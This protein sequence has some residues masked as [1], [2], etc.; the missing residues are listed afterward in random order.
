[1]DIKCKLVE[2]D[3]SAH[4][5]VVRYYTDFMTEEKLASSFDGKGSVLRRPDGSPVRCRTDVNL[6]LFTTPT[7]EDAIL[8]YVWT[9]CAPNIMWFEL[10]EK[11][12][13]PQVD[14][15]MTQVKSM[16]GKEFIYTLPTNRNNHG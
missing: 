2:C 5:V 6:N 4:S 12:A 3:D 1:M 9:H 13:D 10:Q 16:V 14:T 8:D 7:T 15:S 11:I